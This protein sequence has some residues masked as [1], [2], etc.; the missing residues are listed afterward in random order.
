MS[1]YQAL[2][3]L[4]ALGYHQ[5]RWN[6]QDEADVKAVDAG[7]DLHQIPYD[8]IW[9][10]IEHTNMKKYFTW[11]HK[12]FPDPVGLQR[13]LETRG[14]KVSSM[15]EALSEFQLSLLVVSSHFSD[16]GDQRPPHQG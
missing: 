9:L 13:H 16:G 3:P 11:D 7:F 1:G 5:S 10:D 14:R 8:V 6:Y 15:S 12:L 2:P 4:F